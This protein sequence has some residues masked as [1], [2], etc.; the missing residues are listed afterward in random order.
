MDHEVDGVKADHGQNAGKQCR[1]LKLGGQQCGDRTADAARD[2]R[3]QHG[4]PNRVT[5]VDQGSCDSS[6]EREGAFNGQV[7]DIQDAESKE[8]AEGHNGPQQAL[9]NGG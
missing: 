1:D 7:C 9:R 2:Q 3:N 4:K 6:T 5:C 8:D